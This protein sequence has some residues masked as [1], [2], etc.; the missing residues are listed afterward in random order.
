MK[1][2]S[3]N[4]IIKLLILSTL[5]ISFYFSIIFLAS[6]Y[7]RSREIKAIEKNIRSIQ[8]QLLEYRKNKNAK[9]ALLHWNIEKNKQVWEY[10]SDPSESLTIFVNGIDITMPCETLRLE[11][12][13]NN[14]NYRKQIVIIN[15]DHCIKRAR[16]NDLIN[17]YLKILK[18]D[19]KKDVQYLSKDI[20]CYDDSVLWLW[21]TRPKEI[22]TS[23]T[24]HHTANDPSTSLENAISWAKKRFNW[25]TPAHYFIAADGSYQKTRDLEEIVGSTQD[26]HANRKSIHIELVGNFTNWSQPTYA[27]LKSLKEII[28]KIRN[29]YPIEFITGHRAWDSPTTCP[30]DFPFVTFVNDF[31]SGS[32]SIDPKILPQDYKQYEPVHNDKKNKNESL[33]NNYNIWDVIFLDEITA[34]YWPLQNQEFYFRWTYEEDLMINCGWESECVN[35]DGRPYLDEHKFTHGACWPSLPKGT[36][37]LVEWWWEVVCVDRWSAIDNTDLDIWYGRWHEAVERIRWWVIHPKQATAQ[38]ISFK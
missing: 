4:T 29:E 24:I 26:P 1:K 13:N 6:V 32:I 7:N 28:N 19:Y 14:N 9:L 12:N 18:T 16:F 22:V 34:Y 27:Q 31:L 15:N 37:L 2:L 38:I 21:D 17:R 10:C 23:I 35:A 36:V 11:A 5:M 25:Y 20:D 30:W 8:N 33:N 3:K